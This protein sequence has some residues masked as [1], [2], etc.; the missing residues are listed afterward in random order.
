MKKQPGTAVEA[1]TKASKGLQMP[2]ET[3][4]P[5]AA[6]AW[7]DANELTRDRLLRLAHQPK[8]T[9]VEESSLTDLFRTIPSE[10]RAKFQKLRQVL[11]D[12]L[13]GVRVYKVG[14]EPERQVYIVGRAKD[15]KWA[16]LKT[17]VVET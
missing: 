16:G 13:T 9:A 14:D 3:D 4:A 17:T 10:D 5:F 2:S 6:F 11:Q 12:Q 7:E 8:G 1:L 15:G